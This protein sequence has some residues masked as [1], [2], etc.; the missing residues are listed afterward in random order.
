MLPTATILVSDLVG[1]TELRQRLGEEQAERLRRLHDR[2]VRTAI[3]THGGVVIKGLG[4]G[5]LASFSG[6]SEALA[7]A[8]AIQQAAAAHSQRHRELPLVVRLG[9]SAGDVTF[10]QGDVFGTPVIEASRLCAAA[11]GGRIL[12]AEVVRLLVK[13]RRNQSFRGVGDLEL[14]GLPEAVAAVEVS[15]EHSC[16]AALPFPEL[17][18]TSGGLDFA[19]RTSE[20]ELLT[21]AWKEAQAG[22]RRSVLIGG[23]PGIGKTRLAAEL[24]RT[25]HEGGG[26]VLYGRCHEGLGVPFEP[27]VEAL[28]FF[29]EHP[30]DLRWRLG[31]YPGELTRLLPELDDLVPGLDSPLTSDAETEQYRLFEALSSWLA[32]AGEAGGVLLVLDDLHW[33][34]EPTLNLLA[35]V[36]RAASPARLLVVGTFRDTEIGSAFRAVLADLRR[37][38]TERVSL[39]GL[40]VDELTDLLERANVDAPA[41]VLHEDTKGNPFFVEE[42]LREVGSG[43]D[44]VPESVR[45]VIV[46]RVARLGSAPADLLAVAAVFG[47]DIEL[48]PL[49]AVAGI[50]AT[51]AVGILDLAVTA[52]LME[53]LGVGRYRFVHALARSAL[54]EALSVNTRAQLHLRAADVF[55]DDVARLASHLLAAAPLADRDRTARACLAAGDRALTALADA[56][57]AAWYAQGLASNDGDDRTIRIDLLTGLGDAQ[58]RNSDAAFRQ[59]LLDGARLAAAEGDVARLVRAVLANSRGFTSVVGQVDRERL[60]LIET[61]LDLVGPARNAERAELLALQSAEL[62]FAGDHARA[63]R[64]AE[65]AATLAATLDDIAVQARVGTRRFLPC[66]VPDRV[67]TTVAESADLVRLADRCGDPQLGTISRGVSAF[68]LLTGG[69]LS[70]AHHLATEAWA[71]AEQAGQPTLRSYGHIVAAATTDA[72]GDHEEAE[73]LTQVAF[74]LGQEAASPDAALF[75]G[76]GM[77][78]HWTFEGR[79]E[80]AGALAQQGFAE[81]PAMVVWQGAWAVDLA[82]TGNHDELARLLAGFRSGEVPMDCLWLQTHFYFA[83]AQGFGVGDAA[84]AAAIYEALVPYRTLHATYAI[85]YLGPIEVALAIVARVMGDTEGALVHHQAAAATIEACGA[86]R[87]RAL[88]GDQWARALLAAGHRQ[89]AAD[90]AGQTLAYCREKRYTTFVNKVEEFLTTID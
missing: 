23:E 84:A 26:T 15:W 18:K 57:A 59:T 45:E 69:D 67:A 32:A 10:D 78:L 54:Y 46:A 33:G 27:L 38:S 79:P 6:A 36:V 3:E 11:D 65:E 31:R 72:L 71:L 16:A 51:A 81:F 82:L 60:H 1:S 28:S 62:A 85:G 37:T 4:D 44:G 74:E 25:V 52:R 29:C 55:G 34:P 8:V 86:A 56:E 53:E 87:A 14:K 19:G 90:M 77:W 70:Q 66:L 24:A 12:A 80:I 88:N 75:Y 43:V 50:E 89:A 9:L 47:R 49:A 68:S 73:R 40:S 5:V 61:A 7:A 41:R 13:G 48:R 30:R 20:L 42:L 76:G 58:R 83:F 22:Q 21:A 17:L 63:R 39:A 35:H 64:A 2:L